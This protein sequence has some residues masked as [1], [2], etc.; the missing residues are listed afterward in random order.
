M[1]RRAVLTGVVLWI[2]LD[3]LRVWAPSLI[4]IFG[5][6]AETPPELIGGF[7]LACAS[8]PLL[9]VLAARRL[10]AAPMGAVSLLVISRIA[11]QFTNGGNPQ[12]WISAAGVA[13]G[14]WALAM[15]FG[16]DR[17]LIASGT[18]VG[19]LGSVA[20][21]AA[22][23]T[24]GAVWRAD[25]FG[26]L[27]LALPLILLVI[28][29]RSDGRPFVS[30][31]PTIAFA[32]SVFPGLLLLGV[33]VAN[34]GRAS[35]LAGT[36]GLGTVT[37]GAALGVLAANYP[38]TKL[39]VNGARIVFVTTIALTALMPTGAA[40]NQ[41]IW[42]LI[43][44]AVGIPTLLHIWSGAAVRAGRG[45]PVTVAA[46][47]ILWVVFF[48]VYYA[49]YDL[50]YRADVVLVGL[51]TLVVLVPAA[52]S[53]Q[54]I[55]VQ[56][57]RISLTRFIPVAV[58]ALAASVLGPAVT[59]SEE[60]VPEAD[61]PVRVI[62]WNL[63]MGYGMNGTFA[64]NEVA[65]LL[66]RE[67]V[68]IVLLS[69]V[70]R[71]WLLNGGQDQLAVLARMLQMDLAFGPAADPVWGDAVLSRNRIKAHRSE[72]LNAYGAVTGAQALIAETSIRDQTLTVIST[73]LQNGPEGTDDTICQAQELAAL[74]NEHAGGSLLVG[75][76][77]NT[78]PTSAAWSELTRVGLIDALGSARPGPTWPADAPDEE[79][80][81]F[82]VNTGLLVVEARVLKSLASDHLPI[83]VAVV[84]GPIAEASVKTDELGSGAWQSNC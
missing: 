32:L 47:A 57:E 5:Q 27:G 10:T 29:L 68:D 2:F 45:G 6:A 19:I 75:G 56:A 65:E 3:V 83:F 15:L 84:N 4:T 11:L 37:F 1:T 60:S 77:L 31:P 82:L 70:D 33:L 61:G 76:D 63:R 78:T 54:P 66:R 39:S 17:T 73:H 79:I 24:F 44:F 34:V 58:L 81:H 40:G 9:L 62:A 51:A 38:R 22:L 42:L 20:S 25:V 55:A 14:I 43:S 53:A 80:D 23:G 41:P 48:F 35:T 30:R 72:P 7:A 21:H 12:L 18:A 64:V 50:G 36:I 46:G 74:A 67:R 13:V 16:Q 71:G 26:W 49:G 8:V 69:E 52:P 28:S 59:I